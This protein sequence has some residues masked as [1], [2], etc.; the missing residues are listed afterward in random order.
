[1]GPRVT[2]NPAFL[3][4]DAWDDL[5]RVYAGL[6]AE[7]AVQR[8]DGSAFAWTLAH[9][10]NQ[11]DTW[12]NVRFQGIEPHPLLGQERFR[13]GG[14]GEAE[15]WD[16]ILAAVADV[17]DRA[18]SYLEAVTADELDRVHPYDGSI[19]HLR[20]GGITLRYAISRTVA[21]HYF[22]L[23]EVATKRDRLGHSVGDYPGLLS[24]SLPS[25]AEEQDTA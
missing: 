1:M 10:T 8:A 17:R 4:F 24:N 14:T 23:G 2:D 5:D 21:H 15:E 3:L 11:L 9:T 6:S 19:T 7:D 20:D 16:D 12:I 25:N 13:F 22:H 18:K